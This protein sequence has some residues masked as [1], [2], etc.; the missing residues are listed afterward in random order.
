MSVLLDTAVTAINI[1]LLIFI[2]AILIRLYK[3]LGKKL[4]E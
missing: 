1:V 3:F 4:K 2:L